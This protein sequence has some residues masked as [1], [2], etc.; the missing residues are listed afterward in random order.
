MLYSVSG[1]KG[2]MYFIASDNKIV[3]RDFLTWEQ[4]GERPRENCRMRS[5]RNVQVVSSRRMKQAE[6]VER[7]EENQVF[8]QNFSP[9][10]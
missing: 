3:V 6:N 1:H 2:R 4:G 8:F 7:T 5:F 10:M 9:K